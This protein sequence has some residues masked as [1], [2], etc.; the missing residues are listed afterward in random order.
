M[1]AWTLPRAVWRGLWLAVAGTSGLVA[2]A[3]LAL[4]EWLAGLSVVLP[5]WPEYALLKIA[6]GAVALCVVAGT[7]VW[8]GDRLRAPAPLPGAAAPGEDASAGAVDGVA[9][10]GRGDDA[11]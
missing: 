5:W 8:L 9:A 10:P 3:A 11:R 7:L 6:G 2:V 1:D 4:S